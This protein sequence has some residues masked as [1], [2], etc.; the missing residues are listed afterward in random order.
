MRWSLLFVLF[1]AFTACDK[2]EPKPDPQPEP[3]ASFGSID[4][5]F[6]NEIGGAPIQM[7][8]IAHQNPAGNPFSV[9]MLKYYVT[10]VELV[11][12]NGDVF[13]ANN[14]DLINEEDNDSKRIALENIP[15]GTYTSL[16]FKLGVDSARNHTG[17]QDGDLDPINGMIWTWNTGY[18]F[19]K[20]EGNFKDTN[21]DTQLLLYHL[22][23]DAAL[24][25]IE[26]PLNGLEV[27]GNGKTMRLK[28]D[29]N[30]LYSSPNMVDFNG[31][32]NHMST[33][34]G[35]VNWIKSLRENFPSA[36]TVHSIE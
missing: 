32:N 18:I 33:G 28:L 24:A 2:D 11:R 34:V 31:N 27:N 36:F 20:H 25:Q 29:L 9:T 8:Q 4:M 26:L 30:S 14:Y 12:D 21:G 7:G 17:V 3:G 1:V 15:N 23:T 10:N 13:K 16:R 22:G 19:F 6:E 35:D 5:R